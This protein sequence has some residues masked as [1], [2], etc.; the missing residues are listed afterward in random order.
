MTQHTPTPEQQAILDIQRSS[1]DS[2]MVTAFA[3]CAKTTTLEMMAKQVKGPFLA[4][5]FNVKIKKELEKRFP[6]NATVLTMNGLGHKAWGQAIGKRCTLLDNKKTQVVNSVLEREG[7]KL[8][9]DKWIALR[10]LFAAGQLAGIVPKP[11]PH[12]GLREDSL[13]VWKDIGETEW[14]T[15]DPTILELAQACLKESC[16]LAFQGQIDFDDQIYMSA[17][18]GG[19]FQKFPLVFVDE[20]QDLSPLNHIMVKKSAGDRLIVVGDPKQAI[21]GFRGADSSS[22]GSLRKLRPAWHDMPLATTFRCP[23]AIVHRQ[24]SH[25][26][27]FT[28]APGNQSGVITDW[29][30]KEWSVPDREDVAV[31]CR[32]NAPIIS[33]AFQLLKAKKSVVI[34]GRDIGKGLISLVKKI[35]KDQST[36]IVE[37]V[38]KITEWQISE[39]NLAIA[40]KKDHRLAVINDQ[41]DCLLAVAEWGDVATAKDLSDGLTKLFSNQSGRITLATGHKAKGLEWDTVIHL[42]PWRIPSKYALQAAEAGNTAQLDQERNL[43]Y[44]IETRTKRE[45]ILVSLADYSPDK[46]EP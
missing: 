37:C 1:N 11:F 44:V 27:G 19:L 20:A 46:G 14:I 35:I 9:Q 25:A 31:L 29:T 12:K 43:L 2:I 8:N 24:Q 6:D 17:L 39:C 13:E 33:L 32:N 34:L 40:N 41:A 22:M 10:D 42:D 28:A 30:K 15:T 36:P 45:L 3:G 21:Y 23:R 18:F 26:P 16:Q 7:L 38:R 5:A 4:L